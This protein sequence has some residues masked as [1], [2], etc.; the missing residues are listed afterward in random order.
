VEVANVT[1]TAL[2]LADAVEARID[3]LSPTSHLAPDARGQLSRLIYPGFVGPTGYRRL[4]DVVRYLRALEHRCVRI[5]L[6]PGRDRERQER[7][8]D[9]QA[10]L[11]RAG[12][13][14]R[15][16]Q[17]L[18][19]VQEIRWMIEELR[20]SL[21]AQHLGTPYSVSEA[22]IRRAISDLGS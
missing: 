21:F 9:L 6:V 16:G 14:G 4:P 15:D 11:D 7:I 10:Q 22:R 18:A 20:V 1:G 19:D 2:A 13:G 17:R 5:A 3:A 12:R 8:E